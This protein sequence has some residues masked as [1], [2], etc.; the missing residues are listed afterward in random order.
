MR[1]EAVPRSRRLNNCFLGS[2]VA[3]TFWWSVP[4]RAQDEGPIRVPVLD[5]VT[6]VR[7]VDGQP[8]VLLDDLAKALGG[9]AQLDAQGERFSITVARPASPARARR[10]SPPSLDTR[11]A[12]PAAGITDVRL[13]PETPRDRRHLTYEGR[14]LSR[15]AVLVNDDAFVPLDDVATALGAEVGHDG[16]EWVFVMHLT[17]STGSL[18]SR[19]FV[20]PSRSTVPA[21]SSYL[22]TFVS[23]PVGMTIEQGDTATLSA[24]VSPYPY[25]YRWR[26]EMA[27]VPELSG[28]S[29]QPNVRITDQPLVSTLYHV[30]VSRTGCWPPSYVPSLQALVEVVAPTAPTSDAP[31]VA[32][33]IAAVPT[34]TTVTLGAS[35]KLWVQATGTSPLSYYW[36]AS[37]GSL[38][39]VTEEPT[40]ILGP[41]TSTAWHRIDV[42]N[43]CGHAK[44]LPFVI[45][46]TDEGA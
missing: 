4:A 13:K 12:P 29:Y 46:V 36:I 38:T 45:T 7:L 3:L 20:S 25:R 8:H 40:R 41:L 30:D 43:P 32:P 21:C 22:P 10:E 23:S 24:V 14:T 5:F 27:T 26:R 9:H 2:V 37:D 35:L 19:T 39:F 44:S 6:Q 17:Y 11:R 33:L 31:C 42:G 15:R 28:I 16:G 1:Y 34:D 18:L